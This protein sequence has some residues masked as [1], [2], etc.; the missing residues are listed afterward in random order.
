[1]T[2]PTRAAH[3]VTLIVTLIPACRGSVRAICQLAAISANEIQISWH[4]LGGRGIAAGQWRV[5]C[6]RRL[7]V[8]AYRLRAVRTHTCLSWALSGWLLLMKGPFVRSNQRRVT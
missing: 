5:S 6:R 8:G 1:M 2:R 4:A 3:W 7:V